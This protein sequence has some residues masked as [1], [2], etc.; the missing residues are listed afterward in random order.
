MTWVNKRVSFLENF[1]GAEGVTSD[2]LLVT[3]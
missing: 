2:I 3:L 1:Y